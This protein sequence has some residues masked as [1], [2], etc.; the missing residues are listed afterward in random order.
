MSSNK[1][2]N[3]TVMCGVCG[4]VMRDD[5]LKRH[6]STKH[7]DAGEIVQHG[8]EHQKPLQASFETDAQDVQHDPANNPTEA[9]NQEE[10]QPV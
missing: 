10:E 4:K 2:Y 9:C 7:G 8:K 3:K 1:K 6:M 5:H